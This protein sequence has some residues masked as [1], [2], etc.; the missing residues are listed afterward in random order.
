MTTRYITE[1]DFVPERI[2][3]YLLNLNETEKGLYQIVYGILQYGIGYDEIYDLL[4][5]L[6]KQQKSEV[7][8]RFKLQ[9]WKEEIDA[10]INKLRML[11]VKDKYVYVLVPFTDYSEDLR[12]TLNLFEFAMFTINEI[13]DKGDAQMNIPPK[14][15]YQYPQKDITKLICGYYQT[16]TSNFFPDEKSP[17]YPYY[18]SLLFDELIRRG[19]TNVPKSLIKYVQDLEVDEDGFVDLTPSEYYNQPAKFLELMLLG[20][21]YKMLSV[22]SII[23][24]QA[25]ENDGKKA[26]KKNNRKSYTQGLVGIVYFMLKDIAQETVKKRRKKMIVSLINYYLEIG[27]DNDTTRSYIDRFEQITPRSHSLKFY[28]AVKEALLEYKFDVP[29]VIEEGIKINNREKSK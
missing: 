1:K 21:E 13:L 19:V 12:Y 27:W 10:I 29:E 22:K 11:D 26:S 18:R 7:V 23:E 5:R 3:R 6:C 20:D 25:E 2:T 15:S 17:E 8:K 28:N 14:P 4:V 9:A 16:F 24:E